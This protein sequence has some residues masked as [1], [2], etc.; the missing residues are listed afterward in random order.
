MED[1]D[2]DPFPA[3][4]SGFADNF[5][6]GFPIEAALAFIVL[7]V[8]IVASALISGSETAYF[9]LKPSDLELLKQSGHKKDKLIIRLKNQPKTLLA[10]ILISNNFINVGI[11]ILST[12]ITTLL[13]NLNEFPILSFIIQIVVITSFILIFGE[14]IP[15]ILAN[16][17]PVMV[18]SLM[19]NPLNFLNAFFKPL[20]FLLV[21]S[22]S[23]IDKRL[24]AKGH[25]IS[26]SEFSEAIEITVEDSVREDEKNILK[27]IASFIEKEAS[28]IMQSRV[29][30]TA[31]D[32]EM[33]FEEVMKVVQQSGF[34]RI[35]VYKE[36][37]DNVLGILYIKDLLPFIE[38]ETNV[39]WLKL[40]RPAIFVPENK[41]IN[42]LLQEFRIKKIHLA[43]VVDE[44]GG[45]SGI[46]TLEDIIEEIVGEISDE[47]D[48]VHQQ[49]KFR[50]ITTNTFLFEA[51]I[52]LN[53]MCKILKIDDDYFEEVRGESD[54]L[55]GLILELEGKIP[56]KGDVINFQRFEFTITDVT[57]R[58][59]KEVKVKLN[60]EVERDES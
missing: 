24:G 17:E 47:F 18:S 20:S 26:V 2:P 45:T 43:I 38:A 19:A 1:L 30:V 25:N 28:E 7:I 9:S 4:L 21:K 53:D 40:L 54:S 12:Y 16:K 36:T 23:I 46:V 50:K 34:S 32:S 56:E 49:N 3:L 60:K 52:P 6:I 59:I 41:K 14:I 33:S 44:Y 22:T 51:K 13:F 15:K 42:D 39:E 57:S 27:G 11:V 8:L 5:F 55:G 58:R 29:N 48:K 37:F 35:P 10:T 31:L